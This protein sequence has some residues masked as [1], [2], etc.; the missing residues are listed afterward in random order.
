MSKT[1]SFSVCYQLILHFIYLN[2]V[3]TINIIF[4]QIFCL[5]YEIKYKGDRK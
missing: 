5:E 2:I 1:I 3:L 4:G